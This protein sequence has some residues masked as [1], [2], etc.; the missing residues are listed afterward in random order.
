MKGLIFRQKN[1]DEAYPNTARGSQHW[2]GRGSGDRYRQC[3][4]DQ[5]QWWGRGSSRALW[6]AQGHP[7]R[8][9]MAIQLSTVV[10][11]SVEC[12]AVETTE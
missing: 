12:W 5:Q 6:E 9:D 3:L 1:N 4:G 7:R 8:G 10:V 2:P 11:G